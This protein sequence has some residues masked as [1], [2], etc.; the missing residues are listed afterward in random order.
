MVRVAREEGVGTLW[1]GAA[2]TVGRAA[3]LNACQLGIYSEAK[4]RLSEQ[5]SASQGKWVSIWENI[6]RLLAGED[7]PLPRM[8]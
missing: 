3:M 6:F 7:A 8:P 2:P 4:E 5:R 1:C